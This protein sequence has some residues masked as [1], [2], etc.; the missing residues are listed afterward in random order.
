[1]GRSAPW[2]NTSFRFSR[3]LALLGALFAL[4]ATV[5]ALAVDGKVEKEA[6]DL[7]KKAIE[8]DNLNVDYDAAQKKLQTAINKCGADK[9]SVGLK[10][11]LNS[12]FPRSVCPFE[13]ISGRANPELSQ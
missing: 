2:H 4:T 7:Q 9:C 12:P 13:A 10:A 6:R 5:Q 1:M 11:S 3:I 8:Q